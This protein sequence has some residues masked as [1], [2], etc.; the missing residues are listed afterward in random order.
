MITGTPKPKQ[1]TVEDFY[2]L[3][4]RVH[5]LEVVI[6]HIAMELGMDIPKEAT[7]APARPQ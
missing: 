6:V 4:R 5:D 1:P 3:K 2:A 7:E